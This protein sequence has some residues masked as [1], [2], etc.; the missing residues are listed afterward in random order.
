[1]KRLACHSLSRAIILLRQ[2]QA[3]YVF[4]ANPHTP[5]THIH[6]VSH[7]HTHT[8]THKCTLFHTHTS[9]F[10]VLYTNIQTKPSFE[11]QTEGGYEKSGQSVHCLVRRKQQS[12]AEGHASKSPAFSVAAD[13]GEQ[14]CLPGCPSPLLDLEPGAML[15][16]PSPPILSGSVPS[17]GVPL[18]IPTATGLRGRQGHLLGVLRCEVLHF[19][20]RTNLRSFSF[21]LQMR[22][23]GLRSEDV[24]RPPCLW[25]NLDLLSDLP[26]PKPLL[27]LSVR[28]SGR[29]KGRF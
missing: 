7:T 8:H 23:L 5:L 18:L 4:Q 29:R 13:L 20:P 16:R 6:T 11:P 24:T 10:S 2:R 12:R 22:K 14:V 3:F 1:M 21:I 28:N 25:Q 9:S 26:D 27:D 17:D 15:G 19:A